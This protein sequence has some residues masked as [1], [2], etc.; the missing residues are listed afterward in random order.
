MQAFEEC[1]TFIY[2]YILDTHVF[3]V[4]KYLPIDAQTHL[5]LSDRAMDSGIGVFQGP[6]Q[7]SR[8][9]AHA[10]IRDTDR[11]LKL[12]FDFIEE[13]Y[14]EDEY[15]VALYSDH[16]SSFF[17]DEPYLMSEE[18]VGSALMIRGGGVPCSGIVKELTSSVDIYSMIGH[19]VGY[20]I[21][22]F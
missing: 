6:N 4:D 1:D 15:L 10:A 17:A 20:P 5:G 8:Y 9:V 14:A 21:D 16:G 2:L 22:K 12:L 13:H 18:Q 19:C 7:M 3:T 11:Q